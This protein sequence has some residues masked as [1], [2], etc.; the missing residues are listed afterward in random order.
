MG[1]KIQLHVY[2]DEDTHK[3][4]W[5]ITKRKYV[6]SAKKLSTVIREAIKQYIEKELQ[7]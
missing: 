6:R 2:I 1:K 4:L 7:E 5:E 3:K